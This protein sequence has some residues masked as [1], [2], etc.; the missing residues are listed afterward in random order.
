MSVPI[1]GPVTVVV[2]ARNAAATLAAQLRALDR[3]I[4]TVAFD[5]VVVDN[6]STDDTALIARQHRSQRYTVRVVH[7]RNAGVNWARNAGIAAAA[8]GIVL[9]CDADDEVRTGWVSAMVAACEPGAWV[10]GVVD[11]AALNSPRTRLQWGAPVLS[12]VEEPSVTEDG[13]PYVDRTF[14]CTCGFHRSMWAELGGFDNRL[15]GIGGDETEFF[16]RAHAVGYRPRAAPAAVVAYRLRPGARDM[17]RQRFRQGRQQVRWLG[18]AGDAN[19]PS[20]PDRPTTRRALGKVIVAAPRYLW[21]A[22]DRYQW[23]ASVSR[24]LGRLTGYRSLAGQ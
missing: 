2:P 12:A 22:R 6:D 17:C 10:G 19:R 13:E 16:T 5:V 18:I 20:L 14:G 8:D 21:T 15:S 24:H 9:L 4:G 23:M 7:E 11:Y 1:A 3:Q